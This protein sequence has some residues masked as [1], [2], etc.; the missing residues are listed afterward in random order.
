MVETSPLVI[1]ETVFTLQRHYG[2]SRTRIRDLVDPLIA[3]R[4]LR[5]PGKAVFRRALELYATRNVSFADAFSVATMHARGLT[6]IYSWDEDFDRF[7]GI[8]RVEPPRDA[9]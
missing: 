6:A 5:L 1:F 7:E 8:V 9:E 4:G 3:L 2:V